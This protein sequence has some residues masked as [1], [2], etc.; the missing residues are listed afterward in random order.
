MSLLDINLEDAGTLEVLP[1]GD[2]ALLRVSRAM[3]APNYSDATNNDLVIV[4]DVPANPMVDDIR[5]WLPIPTAALKADS[6]KD[7]IK[8][9]TRISEFLAS[10]GSGSPIDTDGLLGLEGWAVIS[11]REDKNGVMRNSVRRFLPR[12]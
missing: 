3:I 4:F 1:D 10:V 2:E 12:R 6:P 9:V 5:V 8:Q 7:Y 11:E